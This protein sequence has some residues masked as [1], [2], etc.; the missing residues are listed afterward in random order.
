MRTQ[1]SL[2]SKPAEPNRRGI[3]LVLATILIAAMMIFA[4]FTVD[5]GY[6]TVSKSQLQA[7]ADATALAAAMDFS[8]DETTARSAADQYFLANGFDPNDPAVSYSVDFGTWDPATK[9]FAVTSFANAHATRV[10]VTA[11]GIPSFFG[12]IAGQQAYSVSAEA[13]AVA[14]AVPR[15]VVMVLD[16]STSMSSGMSNG[17]SRMANTRVAAQELIGRLNPTLDRVGLAVYSKEDTTRD[18]YEITGV[19]ETALNFSFTPTSSRVATLDDGEYGEGT[20]I[21][22][23]FRAGL[24][25]H[26]TDPSPRTDEGLVRIVVMLT[27]GETNAAEPYPFPNDGPSGALPPGPYEDEDYDNDSSLTRWANTI[28]AR[29]IKVYCI[30][31][32]SSAYDPVMVN[33]ASSPDAFDKQYYYHVPEGPLDNQVLKSVYGRI[34]SNR[35]GPTLV[36]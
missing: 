34:G 11:N 13:I 10:S 20:N 12:K 4:A 6:I 14:A 33:A 3:A 1:R 22:G 29:G 31:L 2:Q 23:G 28:R 15:D 26:L 16:C 30:T 35:G 7:A 32:G 18:D 8:V 27:D 17:Q 9:S 25:V 24:D 21:A 19:M 5:V 36:D